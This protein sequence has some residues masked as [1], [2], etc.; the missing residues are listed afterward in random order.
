MTH[1][2]R[3]FVAII[4]L[5]ICKTY[6]LTLEYNPG[7]TNGIEDVQKKGWPV[8]HILGRLKNSELKAPHQEELGNM[9]RDEADAKRQ[10]WYN[11]ANKR[12]NITP[13]RNI[14]DIDDITGLDPVYKYLLKP[15]AT[16]YLYDQDFLYKDM[17][18]NLLSNPRTRRTLLEDIT[19][20]NQ[21][22]LDNLRHDSILENILPTMPVP[23]DR[24]SNVEDFLVRPSS[25]G[26]DN[27]AVPAYF[28]CVPRIINLLDNSVINPYGFLSPY[29]E[30]IHSKPEKEH[31]SH[32]NK[33]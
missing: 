2:A 14:V 30:L 28:S 22:L 3:Y 10:T 1:I 9:K 6:S 8:K 4:L 27:C 15:Y 32:N 13:Y 11:Q 19:E 21:E 5:F 29:K 17:E 33:N 26:F 12:G 18:S 25:L 23:Y 20:F 24:S 7:T 16:N 31:I